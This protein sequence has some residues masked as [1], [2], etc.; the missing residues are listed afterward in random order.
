MSETVEAAPRVVKADTPAV[1]HPLW[2]RVTHWINAIAI[3]LMV[4][5]GWRIYNA[6]P[7]FGFEFPASVTIGGWLGGALQWHFAAMWLLV[8]NGLT[9]VTF[10]LVTGRFRRRLLPVSAS[11]VVSDSAAALRG[12]LSHSD[13]SHYNQVQKLLYIGVLIVG[14]L[15][16]LS[17]LAIWKPVQ[18]QELT[19]LFGGYDTAR[20]VHFVMMALIVGFVSL[21]LLLALL[22]P[23]SLRAMIIGR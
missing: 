23:R 6:S 5:S 2:L 1:V 7:L 20:Y 21:H 22:V 12:Q 9:Y 3:V 19:A 11:G 8:I 15:I 17:G 14:V 18:L 4:M 10:G 13:L 16:V